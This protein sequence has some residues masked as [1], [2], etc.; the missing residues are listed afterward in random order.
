MHDDLVLSVEE[1]GGSAFAGA[2]SFEALRQPAQRDLH[3]NDPAGIVRARDG[4]GEDQA[5]DGAAADVGNHVDRADGETRLEC[6]L[7]R[8]LAGVGGKRRIVDGLVLRR[9]HSLQ[10]GKTDDVSH[11]I[12]ARVEEADDVRPPRFLV[13]EQQRLLAGLGVE[14]VETQ[15]RGCER[16]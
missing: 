10:A 4:D 8:N 9:Q 6:S 16:E 15:R 14:L 11:C 2:K 12:R 1:E 7:Q 3:R 5:R 13:D